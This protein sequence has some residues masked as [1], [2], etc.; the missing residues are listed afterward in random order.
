MSLLNSLR[1]PIIGSISLVGA[2]V[3]LQSFAHAQTGNKEQIAKGQ[4]IFALAG[5][6]PCHTVPKGTPHAGGRAFSIPFGTVYNTHIT[7][8]KKTRVGDLTGQQN[9]PALT[10]R[11]PRHRRRSLS[12]SPSG[13]YYR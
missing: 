4:Y 7:Q 3:L 10:K 1:A 2:I 11:I 9:R 13:K 5:G 12:A 8:E 6:C